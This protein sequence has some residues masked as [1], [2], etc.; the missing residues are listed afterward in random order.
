MRDSDLVSVFYMWVA[1]FPALFVEEAVLSP[2][3][4]LGSFVTY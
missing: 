3:D 4:V 1:S 2:K